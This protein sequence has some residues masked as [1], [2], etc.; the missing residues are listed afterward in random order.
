MKDNAEKYDLV[1]GGISSHYHSIA[2]LFCQGKAYI[3]DSNNI[4][5]TTDWH[6]GL[7]WDSM[8]EYYKQ[9]SLMD[10]KDINQYISKYYVMLEYVRRDAAEGI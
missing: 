3:Y 8:G 7:H 5:A 6:K 9:R 2:G 1:C 10:P 4:N